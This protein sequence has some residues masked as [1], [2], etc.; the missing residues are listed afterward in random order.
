MQLVFF[1]KKYFEDYEQRENGVVELIT[2]ISNLQSVLKSDNA[3]QIYRG[4]KIYYFSQA[5]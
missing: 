4:L 5:S 2:L 1:F 3:M